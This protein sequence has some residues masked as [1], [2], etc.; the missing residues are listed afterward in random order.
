MDA[1]TL[2]LIL[3]VVGG[4]FLV[5]LFMWERRRARPE[6]EEP[7]EEEELDDKL[8]PRIGTWKGHGDEE[9]PDFVAAE[10]AGDQPEPHEDPEQPELQLEP[11][12]SPPERMGPV[13][14]ETPLILSFHITPK[15]KVFD[16]EAIVHAASRCGLEPGEMDV[17]H[18][19]P[20]SEPEST[21]SPL[22]SM[23]NMVKPGTFPFGAMADFESPG[24]TL[25]SKAEGA[26]S[27]PERLE[28]MLTAA[29]CLAHEL[30]AEVR[31]AAREVLT[32]EIEERLRD[33]VLELVA[34]RL[35]DKV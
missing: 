15:K 29:H 26:S 18:R 21:K 3:I 6:K 31:N 24:L 30:K 20:D 9:V 8:E 1:D 17:F 33:R 23:A 22:F 19:Y 16:G 13:R 7:F 34:W 27:D 12:P 28:A 11:S 10:G 32:P 2:R 35:S 4:L 25:F 14:P 5:G